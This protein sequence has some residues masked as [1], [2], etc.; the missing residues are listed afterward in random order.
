MQF[1]ECLAIQP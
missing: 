1:T